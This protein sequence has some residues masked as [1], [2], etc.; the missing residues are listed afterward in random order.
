MNLMIAIYAMH[1]A[2]WH[3]HQM[4]NQLIENNIIKHQDKHNSTETLTTIINYGFSE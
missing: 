4:Q 3:M 1:S 2:K